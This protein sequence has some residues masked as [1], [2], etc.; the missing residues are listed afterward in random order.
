M[1]Q[2][3]SGLQQWFDGDNKDLGG[4]LVKREPLARE[5]NLPS[6]HVLHGNGFCARTLRPATEALY[7]VGDIWFTD[8]PGHGLSAQPAHDMP[9]WLRIARRVGDALERNSEGRPVIGIGHSMGGVLTLMLA[10]ERP[11][12]FSRIILLDPVLF[13]PEVVLAQRLMRKTGLWKRTGLVKAVAARRALWPDAVTARDELARKSLYRNWAP[14][15]LDEFIAGGLRPVDE[16]V[17]LACNPAWE[18]S[19]FGSYPRG[20]WHAVRKLNVRTDILVAS[21]SYGFIAR[22]VRRA[23]ASNANIH[24]QPVMGTH[25]FPMESPAMATRLISDLLKQKV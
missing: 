13:S 14:E 2:V 16:E 6:L 1:T 24:W 8:V 18:A 11:Q 9:D 3:Q 23:V 19:I 21:E 25:C 20:L 4:W 17:A 7:G 22:A 10:A 15:A 5:G 12:L